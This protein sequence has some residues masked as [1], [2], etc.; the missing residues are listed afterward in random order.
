MQP[1]SSVQAPRGSPS[2]C[3][4]PPRGARAC[5]SASASP[6]RVKLELDEYTVR[7]YAMTFQYNFLGLAN[8]CWSVVFGRQEERCESETLPLS[9]R[10]PSQL[11]LEN[12]S[13][14]SLICF[15]VR[16][17]NSYYKIRAV[18][19]TQSRLPPV[20]ARRLVSITFWLRVACMP[21]STVRGFCGAGHL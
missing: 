17:Q 21:V 2:P 7:A 10:A 4:R 3:C 9:P 15:Y 6:V 19:H 8:C 18:M 20:D 11:T 12:T 14:F 1:P 13:C 5:R 16:H